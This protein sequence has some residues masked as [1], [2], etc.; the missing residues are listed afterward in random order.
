MTEL[1]NQ[2][3]VA[4][5]Q[6]YAVENRL[7]LKHKQV[8][9]VNIIGSPGSG[10]T[11][12]LVCMLGLLQQ[13]IRCAV[14]EGDL[15]RAKDAVRLADCGV[16][17]IQIS[18]GNE[19]LDAQMVGKVLPGFYL[20]DIDILIIESDSN[21][22]KAAAYDLGED[23]R[24]VVMSVLESTDKA[25]KYQAA[26]FHADI[27]VLHKVDMADTLECNIEEIKSDILAVNPQLKLFETSCRK[28]EVQ[29]I[30]QLAEYLIQLAK[31]KKGAL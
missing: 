22:L 31:Q 7:V 30:D 26:F 15:A 12:L 14:I 17:V 4:K 13:K 23:L 20:E 8:L 11:T 10:K 29:G 2:E 24:M 3:L 21:L 9:G 18:T 5:N 25:D 19:S 6:A 1:I 27:A 28:G 16:N